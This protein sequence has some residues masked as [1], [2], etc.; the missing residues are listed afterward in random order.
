[1]YRRR[2]SIARIYP[3]HIHTY[4]HDIHIHDIH[5]YVHMYVRLTVHTYVHVPCTIYMSYMMYVYV[6][7]TCM[8]KKWKGFFNGACVFS[9]SSSFS[10]SY[11]VVL[12]HLHRAL[13]Q[14][15]W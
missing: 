5:V 13:H 2:E 4:I 3:I 9:F 12:H 8:L 1:M 6:I 14:V 7:C 15:L 11:G 10:S